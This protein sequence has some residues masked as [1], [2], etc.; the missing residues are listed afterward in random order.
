MPSAVIFGKWVGAGAEK[1]IDRPPVARLP[2][3][4]EACP[5]VLVGFLKQVA[6]FQE[7]CRPLTIP[8]RTCLL[9]E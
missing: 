3:I 8:S 7:L 5:S 6:V 1:D 4:E 9:K 2:G